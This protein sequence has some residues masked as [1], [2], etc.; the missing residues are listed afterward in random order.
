MYLVHGIRDTSISGALHNMRYSQQL[1]HN[2]HE[3]QSLEG[4]LR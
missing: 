1:V 3:D 2:E 4:E